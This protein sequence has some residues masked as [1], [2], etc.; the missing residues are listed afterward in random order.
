MHFQAHSVVSQT[1]LLIEEVAA[2]F[3]ANKLPREPPSKIKSPT[4]TLTVSRNE[5]GKILKTDPNLSALFFP[6]LQHIVTNAVWV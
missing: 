1:S 2:V 5:A 6:I 3:K 4:G